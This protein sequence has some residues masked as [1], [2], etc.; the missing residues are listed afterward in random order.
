MFPAVTARAF[1]ALQNLNMEELTKCTEQE[2]RP[3]LC[4]LVRCSLLEEKKGWTDTRKQ[5]LY[6]LVGIEKVNDIVSLLQISYHDLEIEIKKEQQLRLVLHLNHLLDP[7]NSLLI[8]DKRLEAIS[9]TQLS[10]TNYQTECCSVSRKSMW[11]EKFALLFRSYFSFSLKSRSSI[12]PAKNRR[13]RL[14]MF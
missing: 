8:S 14:K 3:I 10:F 2:I 13:R 4:S 11:R 5:I 12:S 6:I 7:S 1:T 9:K